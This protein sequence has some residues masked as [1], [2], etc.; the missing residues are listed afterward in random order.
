M[1]LIFNPVWRDGPLLCSALWRPAFASKMAAEKYH[2]RNSP[3][4]SIKRIFLCRFCQQWHYE[5]S[6]PSPS[7]ES[8]GTARSSKEQFQQLKE[9]LR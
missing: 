7:G 8:S 5:A 4:T 1:S 9:Q 2:E 6:S 3:R